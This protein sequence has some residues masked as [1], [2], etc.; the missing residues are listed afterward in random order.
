MKRH[1]FPFGGCCIYPIPNKK[2]LRIFAHFL[3]FPPPLLLRVI[4]HRMKISYSQN[5]ESV[6]TRQI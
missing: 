3:I 6:Q 5:E 4:I 1:F 2:N